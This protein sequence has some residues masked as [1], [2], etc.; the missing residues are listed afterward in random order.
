MGC[1]HYFVV[2]RLEELVDEVILDLLHE[3]TNTRIFGL[4][5]NCMWQSRHP[6]IDVHLV[7]QCEQTDWLYTHNGSPRSISICIYVFSLCLCLSLNVQINKIG[8]LAVT[9]ETCIDF[10]STRTG[11]LFCHNGSL[12]SI[13]VWNTVWLGW[14]GTFCLSSNFWTQFFHSVMIQRNLWRRTRWRIYFLENDFCSFHPN[15][16]R[17]TISWECIVKNDCVRSRLI[18]LQSILLSQFD[19]DPTHSVLM[20]LPCFMHVLCKTR[21]FQVDRLKI[22]VFLFHRIH[23]QKE[24]CLSFAQILTFRYQCWID[25]GM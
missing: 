24:Y 23:K 21:C 10:L 1:R 4:F 14:L 15:Y 22:I 11:R 3:L 19:I 18:E 9:R 16:F 8:V 20:F 5:H 13:M 6:E 2:D 17:D 25:D 7:E 12:R